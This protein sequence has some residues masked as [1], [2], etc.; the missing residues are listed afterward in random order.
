MK[1]SQAL[2]HRTEQTARSALLFV[3][4]GAV[5]VSGVGVAAIWRH[6]RKAP[7][8]VQY[9]GSRVGNVMGTGGDALRTRW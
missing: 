8:Q 1:T 6:S 7:D 4:A 9:E 5:I 2:G 3:L